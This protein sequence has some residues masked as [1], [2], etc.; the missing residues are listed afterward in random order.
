MVTRARTGEA[1]HTV[2]VR[3]AVAFVGIVVVVA[4]GEDRSFEGPDPACETLDREDCERASACEAFLGFDV[5]FTADAGDACY[6]EFDVPSEHTYLGCFDR[7]TGGSL[8]LSYVYDPATGRCYQVPDTGHIPRGW[9][10]CA[11]ALPMC[12]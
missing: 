10:T 3:L 11:G 6:S 12:P 5:T 1:C 7:P 2:V 8:I 9:P 4:C